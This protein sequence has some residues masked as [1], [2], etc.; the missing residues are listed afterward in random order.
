[1]PK[2]GNKAPK[3]KLPASNGKTVSLSDY[4]GKKDIVLY[5]YPKDDTPGCTVE[6]CGFR[7]EIKNIKKRNAVVLGV[8]PDNVAKHNKFIEK[9]DLPFL[10]LSDEEKKTCQD[11][12]VWVE[13]SMYGRKYMGVARSTF[14]IGKDLK[15]KKIFEKVKPKEHT[16]EVLDYLDEL[17]A[18]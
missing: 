9:F 13:K 6:A 16:Q 4:E 15:V 18:G 14:I 7:D 10:L 11:Y 1:M 12:G 2:V 17:N 3:I 8:S 5:F